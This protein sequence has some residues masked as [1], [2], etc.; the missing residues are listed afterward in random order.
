MARYTDAG[1][2]TTP[3]DSAYFNAQD[4]FIF[5]LTIIVISNKLTKQHLDILNNCKID[6]IP[7]LVVRSKTG[8]HIGNAMTD[9]GCSYDDARGGYIDEAHKK[10]KEDLEKASMRA[11]VSCFSGV[12]LVSGV[13][14]RG[15]A[16]PPT[17]GNSPGSAG[18][19]IDEHNLKGISLTAQVERPQKEYGVGWT[20]LR[21]SNR[22]YFFL[23]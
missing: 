15:H 19:T 17:D 20:Q 7:S 11:D 4:L 1:T 12:F 22:R 10:F 23:N 21:A 6:N 13:L 9:K 18:A 16:M 8:M 3:D 5:D 2:Q 14:L